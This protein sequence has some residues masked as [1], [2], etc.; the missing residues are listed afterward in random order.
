MLTC[1][2]KKG[3]LVK[4]KI[5]LTSI[6]QC[7]RCRHDSLIATVATPSCSSAVKVR[8]AP[9]FTLLK[10][11]AHE[12]AMKMSAVLQAE[13]YRCYNSPGCCY[14]R[15]VLLLHSTSPAANLNTQLPTTLF[16]LPPVIICFLYLSKQ[17]GFTCWGAPSRQRCYS[18]HAETP[19]KFVLFC[20]EKG[21]FFIWLV[22]KPPYFFKMLRF[23]IGK[24]YTEFSQCSF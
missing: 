3:N 18:L 23:F 7:F 5:W 9:I 21:P 12:G 11:G 8:I 1:P 6:S 20:T 19:P 13:F 16:D 14:Y 10:A 24:D 22:L 4:I 2:T 15:N 17:S